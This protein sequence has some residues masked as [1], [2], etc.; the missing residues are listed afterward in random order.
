MASVMVVV[1]GIWLQVE[2]LE[3]MMLMLAMGMVW[4]AEAINTALEQA[5]DAVTLER[6]ERIG[7]AKDVAAGAVLLA[8]VFALAVGMI[9]FVPRV[10]ERLAH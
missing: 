9:V 1:L 6:D 7:R 4:V 2:G 8:A 3:W 10:W 5:C